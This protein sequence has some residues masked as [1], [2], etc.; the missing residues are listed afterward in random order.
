MPKFA[1]NLSMAPLEP[2]KSDTQPTFSQQ[3]VLQP[4][5]IPPT[6]NIEP[7]LNNN[8]IPNVDFD[9]NGAGLVNPLE[10]TE[11]SSFS[12][13]FNGFKTVSE[14]SNEQFSLPIKS[15]DF[16]PNTFLPPT[17]LEPSLVSNQSDDSP[18]DDFTEFTQAKPQETEWQNALPLRETHISS[19]PIES[20][21][22]HIDLDFLEALS[23]SNR[24]KEAPVK[25]VDD[26]D[27]FQMVLPEKSQS[28]TDIPTRTEEKQVDPAPEVQKPI[29][30]QTIIKEKAD[31]DEFTDFYSS[32]P[33]PVLQPTILEPLRPTVMPESTSR[34]S[35]SI[36]WP[37]PGGISDED[38]KKLEINYT[39]PT[40]MAPKSTDDDEWTDF[41]SVQQTV[42]P[43]HK[44]QQS[45]RTSS[46]DLPLS[47][48]NL[49]SI[50]SPKKPIP[51]ITPHGIVQTKLAANAQSAQSASHANGVSQSPSHG[52]SS[53]DEDDWSDFVSSPVIQNGV[54]A[55]GF[56]A[57]TSSTNYLNYWPHN[58]TTNTVLKSKSLTNGS[59]K[60]AIQSKRGTIPSISSLPDLD[61]VA[62]NQLRTNS[63]RK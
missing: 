37:A 28:A 30:N 57:A 33:P 34:S 14:S 60:V 42:S 27:D 16:E 39:R 4:T 11:S 50:K 22:T 44:F 23:L 9:W 3:K 18:T 8:D 45:E 17:S 53:L 41:V 48:L 55:S 25:E 21:L 43:L 46:P 2:I 56:K 29:E 20:K 13:L 7:P 52:K 62:P 61:F 47:V 31:E 6:S 32:A 10:G 58:Q 1:A 19:Q 35:K 15:L 36:A 59:V 40:E 26:F 51:V 49:A 24:E 63:Y 12:R 54:Q 38:L 5:I